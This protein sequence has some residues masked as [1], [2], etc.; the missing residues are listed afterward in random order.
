[1]KNN[2]LFVN[3]LTFSMPITAFLLFLPHLLALDTRRASIRTLPLR[4][5]VHLGAHKRTT[6]PGPLSQPGFCSP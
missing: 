4:L 2:A 1:M 6:K 5:A 3:V